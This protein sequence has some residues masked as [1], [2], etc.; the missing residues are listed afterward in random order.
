MDPD[1]RENHLPTLENLNIKLPKFQTEI[2]EGTV[3]RQNGEVYYEGTKLK[4]GVEKRSYFELHERSVV[5]IT[6]RV[7]NENNGQGF[8]IITVVRGKD[9]TYSAVVNV[10]N[11][12]RK[13]G[14]LGRKLWEV[15][16][17]QIEKMANQFNINIKHQVLKKPDQGL[18]KDKWD[19]LFLPL[20]TQHGYTKVID[21]FSPD[22]HWEKQYA[23]NEEQN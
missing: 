9:G 3:E 15:G 20:L 6:I 23:K 14:G 2:G 8:V 19:E 13:L 21:K 16:I 12:I 4:L 1:K 18:D 22:D 11:E 17:S 7:S 10:M 5:R